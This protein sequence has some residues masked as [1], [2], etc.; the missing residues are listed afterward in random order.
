MKWV[1]L[2]FLANIVGGVLAFALGL[3]GYESVVAGVILV[4]MIVWAVLS[5]K[6]RSSDESPGSLAPKRLS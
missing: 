2:Y 3:R 1:G 4:A 6:R 5:R